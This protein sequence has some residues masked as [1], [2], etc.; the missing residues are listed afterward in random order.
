MGPNRRIQCATLTCSEVLV[1]RIQHT[2]IVHKLALFVTTIQAADELL[3]PHALW[4]LRVT[5][6]RR[7]VQ[8]N[9]LHN[10]VDPCFACI[11]DPGV[12]ECQ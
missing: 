6:K 9:G 11:S 10:V 1:L 12:E 8:T 3:S 5:K 2:F 4:T 7:H